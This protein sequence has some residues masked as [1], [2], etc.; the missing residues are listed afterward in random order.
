MSLQQNKKKQN[1]RGY[2]QNWYNGESDSW[3]WIASCLFVAWRGVDALVAYSIIA[4]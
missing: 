1:A 2:K 3:S 4:L